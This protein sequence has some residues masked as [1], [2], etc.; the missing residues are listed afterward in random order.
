[1][2][3]AKSV[4][5]RFDGEVGRRV[6][7][8]VETWLLRAPDA[9][10]GIIDMFHR[11]DRHLP[12]GQVVP[13]AGEFAG[14]YLISAVQA[15][16]MT[17]DPRLEPFV[18]EFVN[19]LIDSQAEDGYL[20]PFTKPERLLAH[21]DLWGHYHCMQGLLLWHDRT[22]DERALQCVL[23]AADLMCDL[24]VGTKHRP[25]QAGAPE[26]NNLAVMH[27]IANL[28]RRTGNPR[29]MQFIKV[30]EED[31]TTVGD[32]LRQG[33]AGTPFFLLNGQGNRWE[34]LH[35]V[36]GLAEMYRV[37]GDERYKKAVLTLWDSMRR[38]DRHPS[39]AFSTFERGAGSVYAP[40]Q[41][42]TCCSIAWVALTLDVLELTGDAS[43]ADELELTT[44]NQALAAQH[45]SGSWC[46]Y[47]TPLN[48]TRYPAFHQIN[49]QA[50][51]SAP[52]LNCCAP[53]AP[54][55]LT[56]LRSWGIMEDVAKGEHPGV[57]VNFY[58]PGVFEL[59]RANGNPLKLT[60]ETRYPVDGAVKIVVAPKRKE[61]FPLRL[62]IP[63]WSKAT[64]VTVNGKAWTEQPSPGTHL[65][66]ERPWKKGDTVEL[67]FDMTPRFWSGCGMRNGQAAIYV[68]PLLLAYDTYNNATEMKN[69]AAFDVSTLKLEPVAV[70]KQWPEACTPMA[71]W[72][73]CTSNGAEVVL[74]DFAN[75]GAHGTEYAAWLP[76]THAA[77]PPVQLEAPM[78]GAAMGP[79]TVLF[80]WAYYGAPK[81]YHYELI[82]A[83]D[84]ALTQVVLHEE[85]P[86][87]SFFLARDRFT[88]AGAYFWT[89]RT[90]NDNG[91]TTDP[92]APR[93]F[94]IDRTQAPYAGYIEPQ[95]NGPIAASPMDGSGAASVGLPVAQGGS[96][97]PAADRFGA[98]NKA[99]EFWWYWSLATMRYKIP[100]FPEKDYAFSAWL[101][102]AKEGPGVP[103][104]RWV[105]SAW[106]AFG[107]DPLRVVQTP[108]GLVAAIETKDKTYTTPAESIEKGEWI[109]VAAV[110]EGAT[111]TLY[112]DGE[113]KQR[114]AVPETVRSASTALGLSS[115]PAFAAHSDRFTGSIDEFAFYPRALTQ[116]EIAALAQNR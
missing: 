111:L 61:A 53:N 103:G 16:D 26:T 69:L 25:V 4:Q 33:D 7:A 63:A 66:I 27:V 95:P 58:G 49:F 59:Q 54:R 42:E 52:E 112:V 12:Y 108:Q 99:L 81:D 46:T 64:S 71:A 70:A 11:R 20:G 15:L 37:T 55:A 31:M 51:P 77:P 76:V 8:I 32:W 82:V 24:Y 6:D 98:P 60:Q 36:Q 101:C 3:R 18:K 56:I 78:N 96:I 30:I 65:V 109:H 38:Y 86:L 80:G 47:D 97:R 17:D 41:I 21:W 100:V 2:D 68:G 34:S 115:N 57:V 114:V 29:Y 91:A 40:G 19:Q 110:K 93:F 45:P 43:A 85:I 84:A 105:F 75:A 113:A 23:R 74:T 104:D 88:E 116:E 89:V 35:I 67:A 90:V 10:P 14:K 79:G 62:R 1:M 9:N 28:Y 94:T 5:F 22:G 13:W 87:A 107:D 50:R 106:T 48:G 92:T 83:K 44:W 102:P 72:K 73:T 39:G